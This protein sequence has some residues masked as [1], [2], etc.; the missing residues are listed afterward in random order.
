M[1]L[2]F[3]DVGGEGEQQD[4]EVTFTSKEGGLSNFAAAWPYPRR[5][6][7]VDE[8]TSALTPPCS[9]PRSEK[10]SSNSKGEE[11]R[12]S[13]LLC[14]LFLHEIRQGCDRLWCSLFVVALV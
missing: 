14:F 11:G 13:L 9:T 10:W 2:L 3:G 5:V 12:I 7:R 4:E 8:K 1:S 6:R